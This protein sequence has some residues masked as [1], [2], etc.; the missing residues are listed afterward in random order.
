LSLRRPIRVV[1]AF[2]DVLRHLE[3]GLCSWI[4][5]GKRS[6]WRNFSRSSHRGKP[7][8][9]GTIGSARRNRRARFRAGQHW[10][11]NAGVRRGLCFLPIVYSADD[12]E[13]WGDYC[14]AFLWNNPD[15]PWFELGKETCTC[16]F[17]G[18]IARCCSARSHI[19]PDV[20]FHRET[21]REDG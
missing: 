21:L 15:C 9:F 10:P 1:S 11:V 16:G 12:V 3:P 13:R 20:F 14:C 8:L 17:V 19:I 2:L 4:P 7:E 18:S 5:G 6:P